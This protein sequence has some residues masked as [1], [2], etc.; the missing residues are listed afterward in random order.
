[1]KL[2]N[3]IKCGD[4]TTNALTEQCDK[5][6]IEK[7]VAK[8][9]DKDFKNYKPSDDGNELFCGRGHTRSVL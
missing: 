2:V 1:M 6:K 4:R 3:C 7:L 5:C 9:G 8:W